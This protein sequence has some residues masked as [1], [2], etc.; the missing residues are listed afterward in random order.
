[1]VKTLVDEGKLGFKDE[2]TFKDLQQQTA[3]KV[4][5]NKLYHEAKQ[6]NQAGEYEELEVY[7]QAIEEEYDAAEKAY[8]EAKA[9]GSKTEEELAIVFE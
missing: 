4:S 3:E 1:M 5:Y 8:Q 6:Y 7:Y 2:D 9:K